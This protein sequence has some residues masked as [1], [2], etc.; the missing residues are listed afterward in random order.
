VGKL[1]DAKSGSA[2]KEFSDREIYIK[3]HFGFLKSHIVRQPSRSSVTLETRLQPAPP[4]STATK[5]ATPHILLCTFSD[6]DDDTPT[7]TDQAT[8]AAS[9]HE[10]TQLA[11]QPATRPRLP[12][13]GKSNPRM[14]TPIPVSAR[15]GCRNAESD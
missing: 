7:T 10:A 15:R 4:T 13:K 1:S 8:Q 12:I 14:A 5:T 11:T 9:H 2:A 6:D 3:E